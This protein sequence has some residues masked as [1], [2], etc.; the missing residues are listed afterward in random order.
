[1]KKNSLEPTLP[2]DWPQPASEHLLLP[3]L[4]WLDPPLKIRV[5]TQNM[6]LTENIGILHTI[7]VSEGANITFISTFFFGKMLYLNT[8][9]W[10]VHFEIALRH[11]LREGFKNLFTKSACGKKKIISVHKGGKVGTTVVLPPWSM[12]LFRH[13]SVSRTYPCK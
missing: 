7:F 9:V 1:M 6:I 4:K 13:A 5:A 3:K 2:H 8:F 10:R 12:N 11:H